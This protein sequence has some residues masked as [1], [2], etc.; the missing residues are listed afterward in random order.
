MATRLSRRIAA[1]VNAPDALI[2]DA[3]YMEGVYAQLS[4]R[5]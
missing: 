4:T 3:D 5:E 2:T 1:I